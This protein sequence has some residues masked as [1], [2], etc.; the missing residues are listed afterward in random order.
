M[1]PYYHCCALLIVALL[2]LASGCD[3]NPRPKLVPISGRITIDGE[4]L[5][6]GVITVWVKDYRPAIG[7]IESDGRYTLLTHKPGDG[8]RPGTHP[9]TITSQVSY[10]ED[11]I[12]YLIPTIYGS[13]ETS[14]LTITV[15]EPRD[16]ADYNL[17]WK[18]DP[19]HTGPYIVK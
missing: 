9:I 18:D 4:P 10:G 1:R 3:S 19:E 6:E 5:T 15:D 7:Q 11:S 17:T 2:F 8:C 14:K 13:P 16:N 12:E